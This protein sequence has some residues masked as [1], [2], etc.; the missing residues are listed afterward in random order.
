MPRPEKVSPW[1]IEPFDA[2]APSVAVPQAPH[3]NKRPRQ[4]T[5][6]TDV[7]PSHGR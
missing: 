3:K 2:S 5:E 6:I 7:P 4:P 1:E